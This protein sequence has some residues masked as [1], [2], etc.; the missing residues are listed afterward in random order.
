M[1]WKCNLCG[2]ENDDDALFCIKCGAQ[3]SSEAQQ[4]PQQQPSEPQAQ[5]VVTQ[6]QVVT[7]PPVQA[8]VATPQQ[9]AQQPVLP[10]PEP[11]Q[12]QPVSS[13][14]APQQAS[15]PTNRYYIYFIQTP[16]ENLVNKK[17]LLNFDLFP[18][19]SMGRSPENIVIVPDSEVS[20]KHAVIYLDNSELYIEDLNSTNGTYVYDGKQFTPIKGK[21]KIEPNSIIKLGNQTIVRILKEWSHPQFEK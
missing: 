3:K 12:P 9:P 10:Q 6:Q 21:Q 4:L 14:P 17:V 20:R 16:N 19:V 15:Q 8:Q 13:T 11:A 5:G 2:Y 1:T 7:N 18:S